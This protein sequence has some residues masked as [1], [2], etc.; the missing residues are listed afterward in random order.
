VLI[1]LNAKIDWPDIESRVA[2]GEVNSEEVCLAI[3]KLSEIVANK[4]YSKVLPH[5]KEDLIAEG[6]L[7]GLKLLDGGRFDSGITSLKNYLYSGLR[8]EMQNYL[9]RSRRE[10]P[11]EE[12]YQKTDDRT[13]CDEI[14][15]KAK[16]IQSVLNE[17]EV[18]YSDYYQSVAIKLRDMG[19]VVSP[20]VED[21]NRVDHPINEKV[22]ER[23]VCLIVWKKAE[24]PLWG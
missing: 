6:V 18:P 2:K 24:D 23:L 13:R 1:S 15:V 14:V 16:E 5:V 3:R 17:F 4:H 8:N 9:Y 12:D 22:R 20:R 7:K 21:D 11:V 10:T 19:F